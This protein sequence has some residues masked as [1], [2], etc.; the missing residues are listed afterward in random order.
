MI[1]GRWYVDS[2]WCLCVTVVNVLRHGVVI[3]HV[4][5]FP[6]EIR[7]E[8]VHQ[9]GTW[10]GDTVRWSHRVSVW[11]HNQRC[12]TMLLYSCH[13]S[14]YATE[15]FEHRKIFCAGKQK[16]SNQESSLCTKMFVVSLRSSTW[17]CKNNRFHSLSALLH[18]SSWRVTVKEDEMRAGKKSSGSFMRW[19]FI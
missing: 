9:A 11:V 7:T 15:S 19:C 16:L 4:F 10:I 14:D 2:P 12:K 17:T 18:H 13:N 3:K 1:K 8:S 6:F 5:K